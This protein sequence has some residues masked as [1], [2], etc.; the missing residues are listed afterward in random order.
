MASLWFKADRGLILSHRVRL[1][2]SPASP[3]R[4][5]QLTHTIAQRVAAGV[6][7]IRG[8]DRI[9][10][11]F[12]D[13]I[14]YRQ[15]IEHSWTSPAVLHLAFGCVTRASLHAA[16]DIVWGGIQPRRFPCADANASPR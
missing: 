14:E 3:G 11:L 10:A 9:N 13:P 12:R 5:T 4:R 16:R 2:T 7:G 6:Q 15:F 8:M 1:G